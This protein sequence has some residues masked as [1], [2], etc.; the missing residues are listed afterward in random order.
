[1]AVQT[2]N[3]E[4]ELRILKLLVNSPFS[5]IDR[6]L[7]LPRPSYPQTRML[8]NCYERA[9]RIYQQHAREGVFGPEPDGNFPRFLR[10]TVKL[11]T[12]I[13]EEDRYYRAWLGLA[14]LMASRELEAYNPT[15]A[16][17]KILIKRQWKDDISFI[18]PSVIERHKSD[19]INVALTQGL[20]NLL[21]LEQPDSVT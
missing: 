10:V 8:Q 3:P 16:Q 13:A 2:L 4:W 9:L 14:F 17:L 20:S 6:L 19:F 11:L 12:F 5:L 7:K 18:R 15:P 21:D 1:M